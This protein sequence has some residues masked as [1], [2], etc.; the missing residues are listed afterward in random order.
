MTEFD[1]PTAFAF[2]RTSP[3]DRT[4]ISGSRSTPAGRSAGSQR[5]ASSRN[6]R[7]R[8][9]AAATPTASSA[10]P[11]GALWFTES[12]YNSAIGRITT[13]G[14]VT[15]FPLP[16]IQLTPYGLTV[17]SRR[18]A[19]GSP[20]MGGNRDQGGYRDGRRHHGVRRPD[21]QEL[22]LGHHGRAGQ[23][24]LV[25]GV[26]R[27]Q[28]RAARPAVGDEL[29]YPF[30]PCRIVDSRGWRP[31]RSAVRRFP[32]EGGSLLRPDGHVRTSR[33]T[34]RP[35]SVNVTVVA[36]NGQ[37]RPAPLPGRHDAAA[38]FDDQLQDG[39]STRANNAVAGLGANRPQ[40]RRP[41]RSARAGRRCS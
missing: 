14:I 39:D 35:I 6:S 41:L 19:L 36:P 22:P 29:L 32:A 11:D 24:A 30:A 40:T 13:T 26:S 31:A 2:A 21:E 5:P 17:R 27:Q 37:R 10:G 25:H 20:S 9:A 12:G 16:A 28:D 23:R 18:S 34:R 3:S 15:E 38:R 7:H 1:V 8:P 33:P 4:T